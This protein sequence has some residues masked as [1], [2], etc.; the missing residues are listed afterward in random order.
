MREVSQ[1]NKPG[2]RT[3]WRLTSECEPAVSIIGAQWQTELSSAGEHTV[4]FIGAQCGEVVNQDSYVAFCSAN[5]KRRLASDPKTCIDSS[6]HT[7]QEDW[8]V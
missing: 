5:D 7:L 1:K 6:Y 8:N 2:C 3:S 4:W